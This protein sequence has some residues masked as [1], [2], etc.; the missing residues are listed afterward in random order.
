MNVNT[1]GLK[2]TGKWQQ[3]SRMRIDLCLIVGCGLSRVGGVSRVWVVQGGSPGCGL[4]CYLDGS[5]MTFHQR[6][7]TLANDQGVRSNRVCPNIHLELLRS[8]K[9]PYNLDFLLLIF[10]KVAQI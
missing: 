5:W 2:E 7:G 3:R 1:Q 6:H 10:K 8:T 4:T 9:L